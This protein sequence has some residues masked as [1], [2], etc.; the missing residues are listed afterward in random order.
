MLDYRKQVYELLINLIN[1]ASLEM[2]ITMESQWVSCSL[3]V[4][5]ASLLTPYSQWSLFMG[6]EHERC[7][8][9]SHCHPDNL[10]FVKSLSLLSEHFYTRHY[11]MEECV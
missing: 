7:V 10:L 3:D 5:N 8:N 1:S 9:P 11:Y 4:L 6:I 2:P